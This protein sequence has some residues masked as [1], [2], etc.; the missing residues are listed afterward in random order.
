MSEEKEV[1]GLPQEVKGKGKALGDDL[2]AKLHEPMPKEA[3]KQHPT[4]T[5]LSTIKAMYIIERLNDVFGIGGW[6]VEHEIIS[7]TEDYVAIVGRLYIKAHDIYTPAQYGGH[8]KT[9]TNTEA[10]DG[11]KSA[12]TDMISKCASYLEI[13][14]EVFKGEAG[15]VPAK[16][17]K[18]AAKPV[19][20]KK[21]VVR[22][23][24]PKK[25]PE[26]TEEPDG[27]YNDKGEKIGEVPNQDAAKAEAEPKN[28]PMADP[29]EEYKQKIDSYVD[30]TELKA[31][32]I[33]IIED[34]EKLNVSKAKIESLK[35]YINSTY[36]S[37]TK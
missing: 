34:A 29:Y 10:A 36:K 27:T 2:R 37:L 28:K 16:P 15:K 24:A 23:A 5:Y 9:G 18:P 32:A 6:D 8:I 17:T 13:G 30:P 19:P 26:P 11:Y 31:A 35:K 33:R 21:K 3:I 12:V 20:E 1:V 14:L 4:K 7:D 22:K 25:K